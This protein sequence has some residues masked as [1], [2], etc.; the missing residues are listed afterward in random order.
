VESKIRVYPNPAKDY[1]AFEVRSLKFE[2]GSKI[3]V[4]SVLGEEVKKLEV[5]GERTVW[6]CSEVKDGIY[7][8]RMVMDGRIIPG[9]FIIQR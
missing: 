9:K 3:R 7:F 4:F 8:Y 6:D 2:V 1:V 5:K